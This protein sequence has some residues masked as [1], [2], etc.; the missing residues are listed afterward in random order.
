MTG[1]RVLGTENSDASS[2]L[3]AIPRTHG[4]ALVSHMAYSCVPLRVLRGWGRRSVM[5][6]SSRNDSFA[7]ARQVVSSSSC[8]ILGVDSSN[9]CA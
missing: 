4:G 9:R 2:K 6:R 8:S 1:G 5:R 7:L 3:V